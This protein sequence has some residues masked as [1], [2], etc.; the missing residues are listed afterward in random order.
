MTHTI[1]RFG[2][3]HLHQCTVILP[4]SEHGIQGHFQ[5]YHYYG[6]GRTMLPEDTEPWAELLAGLQ[7]DYVAVSFETTEPSEQG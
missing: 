5:V 6:I 7:T 4:H 3:L 1:H 2:P